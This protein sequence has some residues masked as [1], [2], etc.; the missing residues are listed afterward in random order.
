MTKFDV[1]VRV[2]ADSIEKAVDLLNTAISA[3]LDRDYWDV[4]PD[5][6]VISA[7]RFIP[8]AEM[9]V[10]FPEISERLYGKLAGGWDGRVAR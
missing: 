4:V 9:H 8:P 2:E 7:K 5:A 1:T 10:E 6:V 3:A